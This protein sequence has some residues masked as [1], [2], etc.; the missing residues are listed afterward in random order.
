[1]P[2][3]GV[4]LEDPGLVGQ[5]RLGMPAAPIARVIDHRRRRTRPAERTIVAHVNPASP[6]IGLALGQDRHGGVV[7]VQPLSGEDMCLDPPEEGCQHRTAAT[8]L[9]G[10]GRQAEGY[11]LP[12]VAFGLAVER[13]M[14][15][16]LL[17]QDHRQQAGAGPTPGN[18]MERRRSLADLL[19]VA[20]GELLTDVLDYLPLPRDHLQSLGD[21]LAQ[22]APPRATAAPANRRS[23]YSRAPRVPVPSDP[24]AAPCV[25]SAGHRA[26]ASASRSA[27]AD[28]R[29]R[30]D[31]RRPW[32]WP[33]P[34]RPRPGPPWP[35]PRCALRAPRPAP[36]AARRYCRGDP[37]AF[38]SRAR[39]SH[40]AAA[41]ALLN[42]RVSQSAAAPDQVRGRLSAG[43]LRTPGANWV[44]PVD[45]VKHV[46][47]LRRADRDAPVGRR[48]PDKTA[49]LQSLG[50]ERH[51]NAVMPDDLD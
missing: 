37:R 34:A 39:L 13:L 38:S 12:G 50:V 2:A 19:A 10:Q 35:L 46:S 3:D 48:R 7:A 17:E 14:L 29:S 41:P 15:P 9:I 22:F 26:G 36:S 5:M 11:A 8:H 51:A 42:P 40:T 47:Q 33:P 20:A 25:P 24:A 45:P 43:H 32:P 28:G 31:R 18:D 16:I 27:I 4:G 1:V 49:A 23:P 21:V 30:L 44:P 6:G